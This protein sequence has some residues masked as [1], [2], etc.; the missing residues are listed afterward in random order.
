MVQILIRENTDEIV[1]TYQTLPNSSVFYS[2]HC[3]F[4]NIL[5]CQKFSLYNDRC[6]VDINIV[7]KQSV[8]TMHDP[9]QTP[10]V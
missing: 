3:L 2:F 5:P 8:N 7:S 9:N 6:L 1:M 10:L 4:I